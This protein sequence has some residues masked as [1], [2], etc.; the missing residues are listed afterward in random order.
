VNTPS[1]KKFV[2]EACEAMDLTVEELASRLEYKSLRRAMYGEIP[3]PNSKRQHVHDLIRLHELESAHT[4]S[5]A[6]EENE[7]PAPQQLDHAAADLSN[8]ELIEHITEHAGKLHT[9]R[10]YMIPA[11]AQ[12]IAALAAELATRPVRSPQPGK[13]N[14]R[15]KK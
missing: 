7:E 5:V 8:E 6:R 14:Y 1:V 3:L 15:K 11:V 12:A 4:I 10:P 2:E 13:V 9:Q